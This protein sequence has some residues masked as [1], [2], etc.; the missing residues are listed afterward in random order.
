MSAHSYTIL[1]ILEP[2]ILTHL[3]MVSHIHKVSACE[4]FFIWAES[5]DLV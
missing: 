3:F 5:V 2:E 1:S 4:T